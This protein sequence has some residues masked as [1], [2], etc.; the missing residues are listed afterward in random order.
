MVAADALPVGSSPI[1]AKANAVA[2]MNDFFITSYAA[3]S[4]P[5]YAPLD[6]AGRKSTPDTSVVFLLSR[7]GSTIAQDLKQKTD[8]DHSFWRGFAR[9]GESTA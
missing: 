1:K 5:A 8:L 6:V 7:Y 2:M 3:E 4:Q 9:V